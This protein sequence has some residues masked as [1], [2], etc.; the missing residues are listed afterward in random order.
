MKPTIVRLQGAS[1]LS[2]LI[3]R[4]RGGGM[5]DIEGS[6]VEREIILWGVRWYAAYL[7]LIRIG[8]KR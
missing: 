5:I 2:S 6:Q 8:K 1:F 7:I 4:W 3:V